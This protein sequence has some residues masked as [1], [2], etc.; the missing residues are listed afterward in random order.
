M[1]A[2]VSPARTVRFTPRRISF[3]PSSVVT[4]ACRS[5]ISR[6]DICG[7]RSVCGSGWSLGAGQRELGL[8][9][10]VEPL[11]HVR[12]RDPVQDLAEER[13]HD[14]APRVGLGDT[15]TLQVEQLLVVEPPG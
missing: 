4:E 9:G 10:L 3:G 5:L 6:V 7:G 2:C 12:Q 1:I 8:D 14:Q 11:A 13:T 15:A